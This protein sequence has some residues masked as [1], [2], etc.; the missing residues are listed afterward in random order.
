MT[1]NNELILLYKSIAEQIEIAKEKH[2][3][4]LMPGDFS[5]KV[6]PYS[7]QQRNSIKR[8]KRAQKSNWKI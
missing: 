1:P 3:Q 8:K 5:L 6:R 4:V 2:Q 7:R